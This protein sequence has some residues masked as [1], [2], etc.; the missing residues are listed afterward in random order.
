MAFISFRFRAARA[1]LAAA[2]LA[3]VWV[4][5]SVL[6]LAG[7]AAAQG[8]TVQPG[9][10]LAIEVLQDST[11]DRTVLVTPDGSFTFPFAGSVQAA[12][13]TP[14]QIAQ[15][16]TQGI[17]EN[18]ATPPNVFVSV[19]SV[20]P[21]EPLAPEAEAAIQVYIL[22]E[23]NAPGP[24][25]MEP[26]VTL[27]QALS[28]TGGFTNFAATKRLQLRRTDPHT[29]AQSLTTINYRAIAEGARLAR[30]VVLIEGDVILVPQRRLFE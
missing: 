20:R 15:R 29:G 11:L 4:L 2:V 26:G 16:L 21:E 17:A 1:A 28:Q 14:S 18:F 22:G 10:T 7:G 8:Y 3:P 24:K 30:D 12:G 5:V 23:V 27:L 13:R 9:D 19:R 6:A 25:Q